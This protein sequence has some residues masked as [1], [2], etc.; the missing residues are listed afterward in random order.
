MAKA[1]PPDFPTTLKP[2]N[3]FFPPATSA[4]WVR[5]AAFATLGMLALPHF[6]PDPPVS[7]ESEQPVCEAPRMPG[8]PCIA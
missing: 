3:V 2:P 4:Y 6:L 8:H 1:C 5:R 7:V